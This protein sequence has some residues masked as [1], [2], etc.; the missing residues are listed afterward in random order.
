MLPQDEQM[1][2]LLYPIVEAGMCSTN[3]G[4][5]DKLFDMCQAVLKGRYK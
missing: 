2:D 5:M 4:Y 3:P 1:L